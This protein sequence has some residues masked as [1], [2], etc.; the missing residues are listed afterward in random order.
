M[1]SMIHSIIKPLFD[2]DDL[3]DLPDGLKKELQIN[4]KDEG[5]DFERNLID[6]FTWA[7]RGLSL[8]EIQIGYYRFFKEHINRRELINKLYSLCGSDNVTVKCI[9]GKT[10][11]YSLR[12]KRG[13]S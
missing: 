1:E 13:E 6:L 2:L 7:N 4:K 5:A 3:A 12:E 9:E 11:V 8:D 10:G